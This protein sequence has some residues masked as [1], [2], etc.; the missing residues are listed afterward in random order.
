MSDTNDTIEKNPEDFSE[1]VKE[2]DLKNRR[3]QRRPRRPHRG[4]RREP[5]G[6]RYRPENRRHPRPR[7]AAGLGRQHE[8]QGRRHDHGAGQERQ[9]QGRIHHRFQE[10]AG[11]AGRLGKHFPRLQEERAAAGPHHQ[12]DPRRKR[13]HGRHGR[14][15]VPAHE[16][17]G[18]PEGQSPQKNAGQG[19]HVPGRQAEQ[20]GKERHRLA[21]HPA[22]GREAGKAE[23]AAGVPRQSARS[24]RAW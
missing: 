23:A 1:L 12:A 10:A 13:L 5:R 7:G 14:G 3:F 22:R 17:G 18:H 11:R 15:D 16:P 8:I 9:L 19:I 6:H 20:E 21:P 2:Y 24:P 4:H